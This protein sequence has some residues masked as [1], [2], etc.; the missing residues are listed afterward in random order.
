MLKC[1]KCEAGSFAVSEGP[2]NV[3]PRSLLYVHCAT[4]GTVVGVMDP[5]LADLRPLLEAVA[6]AAGIQAPPGGR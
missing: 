6:R 4:C 1:P 5:N 2:P 3:G